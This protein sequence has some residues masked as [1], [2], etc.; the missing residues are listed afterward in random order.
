MNTTEIFLVAM[1]IIFSLPY[2]VWRLARTEHV[3]PLVVVQILAGIA[4][5]LYARRANV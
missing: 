5:V 4:L 2:L 1:L 3:A